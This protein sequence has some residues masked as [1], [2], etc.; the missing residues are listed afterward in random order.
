MNEL[1]LGKMNRYNQFD[2]I[3]LLFKLNQKDLMRNLIFILQ[4]KK[5]T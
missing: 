1:T 3:E 4:K 5:K 2:L